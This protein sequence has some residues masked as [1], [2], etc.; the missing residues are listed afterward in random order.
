MSDLVIAGIYSKFTYLANAYI[1]RY[2]CH[3]MNILACTKLIYKPKDFNILLVLFYCL[4]IL[5][6]D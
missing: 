1:P 3:Q 6:R 4:H 5:K 2:Y